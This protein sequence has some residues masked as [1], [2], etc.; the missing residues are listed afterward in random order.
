MSD[1]IGVALSSAALEVNAGES[2]ELIATIHNSS[3]IVDQF[4]IALE[5]LD[6]TSYDFLVSSVSLSPRDRD[7]V[8]I[9]IHPRELPRLK[10]V[11]IHSRLELSRE[12]IRSNLPLQKHQ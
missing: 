9:S 12:L 8:W 10:L 11:V 3:Q 6:S 4:T 1:R 7:Q 5:G 2:V